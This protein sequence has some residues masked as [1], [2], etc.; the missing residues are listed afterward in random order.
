MTSAEAF[1]CPIN[2]GKLHYISYISYTSYTSYR[3]FPCRPAP[4]GHPPPACW[5]RRGRLGRRRPVLLGC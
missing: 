2:D 1:P 4:G 3:S 5:R